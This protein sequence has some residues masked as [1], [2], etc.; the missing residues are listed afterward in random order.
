M[1]RKNIG[2]KN[3]MIISNTINSYFTVFILLGFAKPKD[4][5]TANLPHQ[6]PPPPYEQGGVIRQQMLEIWK[7]TPGLCIAA[8]YIRKSL[9]FHLPLPARRE[10]CPEGGVGPMNN[11]GNIYNQKQYLQD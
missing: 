4:E 5:K 10:G 11:N 2:I 3:N 1:K 6:D 9:N 7:K 8:G